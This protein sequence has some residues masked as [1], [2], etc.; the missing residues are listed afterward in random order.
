MVNT[1]RKNF[2]VFPVIY[3]F[4][5]VFLARS[6]VK[7]V[8]MAAIS[9]ILVSIFLHYHEKTK[10]DIFLARWIAI[11]GV[12][13]LSAS[14]ILSIE[15][16]ELLMHPDKLSS[17]SL[18]PVVACSPV[19]SSPQSSVF[20]FANTFIGIFGFAAVFTAG[21]TILA[22]ANKL[23]KA[24]WRTLL[25][26]IL[27]GDIF[28]IWLIH[29]GV[30]NIGKLCLYCMMVWMVTFALTWLIADYCIKNKYINLGDRLNKL[31]SY[32]Y[33]LLVTTYALLFLLIFFK[34]SDYWIGLF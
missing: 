33:E 26:G 21:M 10:P 4:S 31:L 5:A 1:L 17:C 30:F 16:V 3:L 2:A 23:R 7:Y 18:S 8:Y 12:I 9:L 6:N 11:L 19:I 28:C 34:W 25:T 22:G 14:V 20:G 29:E 13:G 32:K 24:W 27:L 15:K